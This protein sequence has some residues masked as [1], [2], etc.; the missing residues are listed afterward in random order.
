MLQ[1]RFAQDFQ[2]IFRTLPFVPLQGG[3][4]VRVTV[5]CARQCSSICQSCLCFPR[6]LL[7]FPSVYVY[8]KSA[9]LKLLYTY[10]AAKHGHKMSDADCSVVFSYCVSFW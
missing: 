7:Q 3:T 6:H 4:A 1:M 10:A 5:H 8:S 2:E 9:G